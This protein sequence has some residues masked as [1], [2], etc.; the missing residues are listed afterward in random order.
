MSEIEQQGRASEIQDQLQEREQ[1]LRTFIT[2]R[3]N[4]ILELQKAKDKAELEHTLVLQ[5]LQYLQEIK[6]Y[7][8]P[9]EDEEDDETIS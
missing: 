4:T 2:D 9:T 5:T 6:D 3:G 7:K 1:S 8:A